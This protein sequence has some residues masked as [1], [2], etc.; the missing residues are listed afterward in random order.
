MD[1]KEDL[2]HGYAGKKRVVI[3]LGREGVFFLAVWWNKGT[4]LLPGPW[5]HPSAGA[6]G[7]EDMRA[8]A[9]V[10]ASCLESRSHPV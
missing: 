4:E 5:R 1:F 10:P 8:P 3:V 7:A 9:E 2:S 6:E